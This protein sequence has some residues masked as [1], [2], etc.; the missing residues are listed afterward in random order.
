MSSIRSYKLSQALGTYNCMTQRYGIA[1]S[2]RAYSRLTKLLA[3]TSDSSI[4][5][6]SLCQ[7]ILA[8][9]GR[10]QGKES[11]REES[12]SAERGEGEERVKEK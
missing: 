7:R 11:E 6:E 9:E 8:G 1:P 5:T 10:E 12:D 2:K 3:D 4:V